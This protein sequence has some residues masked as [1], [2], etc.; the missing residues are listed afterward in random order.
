MQCTVSKRLA[1]L[2]TSLVMGLIM[3][4]MNPAV[5]HHSFAMFDKTKLTTIKGV[6]TRIDWANPHTYVY[7]QTVD[8]QGKTQQYALEC[9]SPNE[10]NRW[11]W[12]KNTLQVGEQVTLGMFPMRDGQ[13]AGL[14]FSVTKAD[15]TVLKAH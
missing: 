5:A 13:P 9:S 8:D 10:L 14:T 15:G 3:S 1:G 4:V 11:G 12:K 6:V 7:V 2:Q